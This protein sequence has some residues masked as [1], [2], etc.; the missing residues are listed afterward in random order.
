M[1][2]KKKKG[3]LESFNGKKRMKMLERVGKV[4]FMEPNDIKT[5]IMDFR[6]KLTDFIN[7]YTLDPT[8]P[9]L[10]VDYTESQMEDEYNDLIMNTFYDSLSAFVYD[11]IKENFNLIETDSIEFEES[12][13]AELIYDI[14][15]LFIVGDFNGKPEDFIV[16]AQKWFDESKQAVL[17]YDIG[18][19]IIWIID[20]YIQYGFDRYLEFYQEPKGCIEN[21]W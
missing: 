11:F 14:R 18:Y 13:Y 4:I 21:S 3:K 8:F 12:I 10:P 6:V 1:L 9:N 5:A 16:S 19:Q 7:N 20:Y 17:D 2:K 15:E